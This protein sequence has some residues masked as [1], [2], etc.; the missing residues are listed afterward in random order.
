[1]DLDVVMLPRAQFALTIMFERL[2]DG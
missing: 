2:I 1:M